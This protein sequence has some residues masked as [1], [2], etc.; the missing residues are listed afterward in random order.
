M[1]NDKPNIPLAFPFYFWPITI[2]ALAGFVDSIY[3]SLSHYRVYTNIAYKSFCAISRSLNC[4]TVS[5]SPYAIFLGIPVAVWCIQRI[6]F[7]LD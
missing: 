1:K 6:Q 4:D 5:Q 3:L 2:L 7:K